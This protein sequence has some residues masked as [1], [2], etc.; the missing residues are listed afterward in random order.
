[1]KNKIRQLI[2]SK[3]DSFSLT[4]RIQLSALAAN[5]ITQSAIF[6]NS[7][8]IACYLAVKNEIDTTKL[9]EKI[10]SSNKACYLPLVDPKHYGEMKF[11]QY[12]PDDKLTINR[13]GI[14]EPVFNKT[15]LIKPQDL[16]LVIMPLMAFDNIGYRIGTGGG[17]YDRAFAFLKN[18]GKKPILLGLAYALQEVPQIPQEKW[19]IKLNGVATEKELF[20]MP[21]NS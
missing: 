21:P 1:M 5:H 7:K 12:L 10:W 20:Y 3:R 9:I 11:I 16:D 17:Y 15:K 14:K 13:F 6:Q 19:D 2:R 8:S 4:E 18:N